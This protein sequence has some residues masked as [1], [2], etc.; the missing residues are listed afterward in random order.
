MKFKVGDYVYIDYK[1]AKNMYPKY[2]ELLTLMESQP[3]Q[4]Y[5]IVNIYGD[6]YMLDDNYVKLVNFC[7]NIINPKYTCGNRLT[8]SFLIH[9]KKAMF[10]KQLQDIINE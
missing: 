10:K 3:N 9:Y 5:K 2:N 1:T 6:K 8:D 7:G 4:I